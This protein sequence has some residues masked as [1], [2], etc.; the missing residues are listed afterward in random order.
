MFCEPWLECRSGLETSINWGWLDPGCNLLCHGS[1]DWKHGS[2]AIELMASKFR[3]SKTSDL[4]PGLT[5]ENQRDRLPAVRDA[6]KAERH[7]RPRR[8]IGPAF[9]H[10]RCGMHRKPKGI[11]QR[12]REEA[13]NHSRTFQYVQTR[14]PPGEMIYCVGMAKFNRITHVNAHP[15]EWIRIHRPKPPTSDLWVK[16]V[17]VLVCLWF[18]VK[19]L[20]WLLL[21]AFASGLLRVLAK[22]H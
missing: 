7:W 10:L 5:L 16:I 11:R 9:D 2:Q 15:D 4:A 13:P 6:P 22:K 17:V 21:G 19:L 12:A 14:P 3:P 1:L 8:Q 20:P 18:L